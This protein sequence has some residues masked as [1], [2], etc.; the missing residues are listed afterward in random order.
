MS[1]LGHWIIF[2][3]MDT[4]KLLILNIHV[5]F[6]ADLKKNDQRIAGKNLIYRVFKFSC[7]LLKLI[8]RLE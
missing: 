8:S 4:Y 5:D 3:V 7:F 6:C 2:I 1:F